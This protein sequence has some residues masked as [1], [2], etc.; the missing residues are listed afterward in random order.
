MWDL[1]ASLKDRGN[2]KKWEVSIPPG[3]ICRYYDAPYYSLDHLET[4]DLFTFEDF[5]MEGIIDYLMEGPGEWTC[6]ANTEKGTNG[7]DDDDDDDE[8]EEEEEE[9]LIVSLEYE[10]VFRPNRSA[11]KGVVICDPSHHIRA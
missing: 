2:H 10:C 7:E 6:P 11:T 3:E 9:T 1:Y 4:L 8:V 5:N